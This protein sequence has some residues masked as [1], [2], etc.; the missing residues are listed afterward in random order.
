MFDVSMDLA[1]K[2]RRETL[3][4]IR[5]AIQAKEFVLYYQP[6]VEMTTG[7]VYGAE[8]LIRWLHPIR[9]LIPPIQFLPIIEDHD[10]SV[11]LGEWVIEE[12]LNQ[13][14][15]WRKLGLNLIVSV[16]ISA[17]QILEADFVN[18][19]SNILNKF[20]DVPAEL[21]EL[22]IL[23]TSAL[24]DIAKV[25][26]AMNACKKL[27]IHFSI[28]DFGTG[29]SSLTYLKHLPANTLKIDQ[30]FVKDMMQYPDDY[31]IVRGIVGL[32]LAFQRDVIAEGMEEPKL[33]KELIRLGCNK[34][35]GY[36]IARPMPAA[37]FIPWMNSWTPDPTW[38]HGN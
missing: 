9:G 20:P 1:I 6:K 17:R 29:Y 18:K 15:I 24:E 16:N 22:E 19:L 25:S 32:A 37:G 28:D 13:I 12:A 4:Q 30:T 33:G 10:E 7:K 23:E 3:N 26:S 2:T 36:G 5:K 35:Q 27:G 8:A 14:R 31:T 11:V 34:A 21:I 38:N